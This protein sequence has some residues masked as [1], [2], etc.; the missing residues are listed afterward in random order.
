MLVPVD[1]RCRGS[2][3][4]HAIHGG[5]AKGSEHSQAIFLESPIWISHAADKVAGNVRLASYEVNNTCP[6]VV[7]QS[8]HGEVPALKIV[9]QAAGKAD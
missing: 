1:G 7:G 8:V 6:G 5:E 3:D 4:R 2:F 9:L